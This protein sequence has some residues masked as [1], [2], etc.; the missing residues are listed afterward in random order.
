MDSFEAN[1]IFGALLG[2]VFVLFGGS[3][4]AE[5]IFHAEIPEQ[6]GYAIVAPEPTEGGAAAPEAVPIATLLQ[7]AD[8][9]AGATVFRRCQACHSN[10]D[11]APAGVGPHL[12]NVV[13][14]EVAHDPGFSYSAAMTAFSEGGTVVWD[15]Q[16]LND[17]LI[18]PRVHIPGTAMSF[19]GIQNDG[20]RADLIAYLRTLSAEP[21]PLPEAP[22]AGEEP[23]A[24]GEAATPAEGGE[25]AAPAE[26]EAAAPA[27]G[28]PAAPAGGEAAPAGAT[29]DAAP[30]TDQP[31]APAQSDASASGAP[32]SEPGTV[33]TATEGMPP[34]G[35]NQANPGDG[36]NA[37]APGGA[38]PAEQP[39]ATPAPAAEPAPA[40]APAAPAPAAAPAAPAPA[41]GTTIVPAPAAGAPAQQ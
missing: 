26:G 41:G 37:D 21:A 36:T 40:A 19:A 4:V 28:E 9:E 6:P 20:D 16:H 14:R 7:T 17:F 8:G 30:G 15:Y 33:G 23:A 13:N 11:G 18:N 2:T 1:K 35:V 32:I 39:A 31:E 22:A 3:L 34:A 10:E 38:A 27:A 24:E 5:N 25:A 29:N 12:W